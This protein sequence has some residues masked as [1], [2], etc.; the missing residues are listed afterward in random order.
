MTEAELIRIIKQAAKDE[1]TELDL[2]NNQISSL[3]R[4]IGQLTNLQSLNI[5]NNQISSLPPEIGQLTNLQ[6]LN[7]YN[8]QISSFP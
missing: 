8:N 2:S 6:S 4:E 3:P 7:I 1:V 5:Y